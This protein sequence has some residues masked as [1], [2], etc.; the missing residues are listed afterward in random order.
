MLLNLK[1]NINLNTVFILKRNLRS[2]KGFG[3]NSSAANSV[4]SPIEFVH[5]I[6]EIFKETKLWG[7][8]SLARLVIQSEDSWKSP[9]YV[10]IANNGPDDYYFEY[11]I[12][13]NK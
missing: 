2:F 8:T 1:S 6:N 3:G 5:M 12:P 4:Q 13:K 7:L 9:G 10:I 11:L